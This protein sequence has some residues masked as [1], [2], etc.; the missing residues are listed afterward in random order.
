M[1]IDTHRPNKGGRLIPFLAIAIL[2]LAWADPAAA[3][4]A[5]GAGNLTTF[6][7]NVAN[8]ITGT[9]GQVLAVIAVAISGIGT[10]FGAM[11]FRTLGGVVLGCA[12]VFSAAWIVSQITGGSV[13]L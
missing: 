1:S 6:L 9:A 4:A 8:L 5:G 3:Q 12:I 10:M 11:S 7:Q 2:A 13:N